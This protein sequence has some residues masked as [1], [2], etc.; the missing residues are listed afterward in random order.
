MLSLL[1]L[2]VLAGAFIALGAMFAT[3][4]LAGADGVVPF[5]LSRLLAGVGV[6][7]RPGAGRG[8]RRRAVH[9]QHADGDG[10]GRPQGDA[11]A[12]CCA[13]GRSSISATSSARSAPPGWCSCPA[14]ISP[15]KAAWRRSR[16]LSR[17]P[18][19]TLPFDQ[20]AVPRHPVQ[21]AGVPG[22]L[23]RPSAR[24][25]T[26]DKVLAI[27]FPVSA[28][29]VAG[30]EHS[31]A[32]MYFIPLGSVHQGVGAA[33]AVGAARQFRRGLR[34]ADLAGV[35]R[36]PDPGDHR[37]YH[38]RR[39]AGR[40]GL[41]VHLSA[42]A[43]MSD[44]ILFER[45]GAAGI[46]TLNR[47]KALNAVTHGMVRALRAQLD[48]WADDPAVTRVVITGRRRARLLGRRRYPRALRSRPGRPARRGACSSG[49]TNI[50]STPRSRI[51][52]KPYVALI[53]G[54]VMGGGVGVSVHGSH[55][56][57]GDRFQFAMPEVGIGFFPDV[58]A[59]WFL[60]RMPGELG[61]Y[62][63]LTGERFGAADGCAAGL[64]T[65]R[66]ASARFRRA[67]RGL[68]RHR[69]G[70][71]GARGL[72]RAGRAGADPG[73]AR[74]DRPAVR[75]RPGRGHSRRAR[76]RSGI[77]RRRR[78][79]GRQ[80]RRHHAHQIAA[81]PQAGAG[82]GAARRSLGFRDV[83]ARRIPHSVARHPWTT[84]STKACA[85]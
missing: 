77:R 43:A 85:R 42:Q 84:I 39:R 28:F 25:R 21:R 19:S 47:P 2:S 59:T 32:N 71:C 65:H 17:S 54:I 57:A 56:V 27:L 74:D 4:V 29:V 3:T 48:A 72:R 6:L 15:A 18:R 50:R 46:V 40:R 23:A 45:R 5:G 66:I 55:R 33:G 7:P 30:F 9:R 16:S 20:R 22:G 83:H 26:T 67:A 69:V 70:R 61:T 12:K 63:A 64:A 76:P 82:A 10:L 81:Q 53:D 31:V 80:D 38:R 73:A 49:A 34:R 51:I 52:R 41:L 62:C 14:S 79:M 37:Q 60:P 8:R 1:A 68:C 78:R 35:F 75:R 24:A 58:G 11:C 44:D 13:P 36:Q